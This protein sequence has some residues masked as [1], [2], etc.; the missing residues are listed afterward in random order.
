M[1]SSTRAQ[2]ATLHYLGIDAQLPVSGRVGL[3]HVVVVPRDPAPNHQEDEG[4]VRA[5]YEAECLA[6]VQSLSIL[7]DYNIGRSTHI[8]LRHTG[9]II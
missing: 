8:E 3:D 6:Q 2:I 5:R 9:C 7:L 4:V 1:W